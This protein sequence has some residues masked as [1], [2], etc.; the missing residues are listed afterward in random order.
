MGNNLTEFQN[1]LLDNASCGVPHHSGVDYFHI[2]TCSTSHYY[3]T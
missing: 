2:N 3:L 1:K